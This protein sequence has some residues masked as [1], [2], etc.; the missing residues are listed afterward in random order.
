VKGAEWALANRKAP[1]KNRT[2]YLLVTRSGR[3][4]DAPTRGKNKSDKIYSSWQNLYRTV[5]SEHGEIK[6]LPFKYLEKTATDW[7]RAKYGGEVAN[8]FTSHG[9]PVKS[10]LLLEVYSS[11]P[12]ARLFEAL[13]A[14]AEHL[15]PMFEIA[16]EPWM[17][18]GVPLEKQEQIRSLRKQGE[19]YQ[20]I[21]EAVGLHWVTVGRYCRA[22]KMD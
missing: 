22:E 17:K 12:F 15:L 11:K 18:Q 7:I 10:D 14:L 20:R 9:K 6:Y 2:D 8:L 1:I 5:R 3:P 13:D 4:L 19:T 21:A 16:P